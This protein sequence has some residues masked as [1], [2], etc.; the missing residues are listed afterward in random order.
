MDLSERC[1]SARDGP[2]RVRLR[3][4]RLRSLREVQLVELRPLSE[5]LLLLTAVRRLRTVDQGSCCVQVGLQRGQ[6]GDESGALGAQPVNLTR[7][8]GCVRCRYGPDP[9]CQ[10]S[11]DSS[12]HK[13]ELVAPSQ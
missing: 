2:Q 5:D 9:G 11:R 1:A 13:D 6:L 10:Q 12:Q 7:R 3:A 8:A 4:K